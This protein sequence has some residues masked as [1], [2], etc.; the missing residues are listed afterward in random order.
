MRLERAGSGVIAAMGDAR[1]GPGAVVGALLSPRVTVESG[2]RVLLGL[3]QAAAL[4]AALG[5]ALALL[6]RRRRR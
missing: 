1:I 5:A 6:G 4:G 3:P 2:G